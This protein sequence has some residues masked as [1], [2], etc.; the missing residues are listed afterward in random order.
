MSTL[1]LGVGS[2][3]STSSDVAAR[4]KLVLTFRFLRSISPETMAMIFICCILKPFVYLVTGWPY[5]RSVST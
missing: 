1:Q 3:P 2:G 4:E 5:G